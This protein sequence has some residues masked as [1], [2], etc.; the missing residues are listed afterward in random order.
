MGRT[1]NV[2]DLTD[3]LDD[4]RDRAA[5]MLESDGRRAGSTWPRRL[6]WVGLGVTIGAAAS[7]GRLLKMLPAQLAARVQD[8]T[9]QLTSAASGLTEQVTSLVGDTADDATSTVDETIELTDEVAG[10][11]GK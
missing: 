6:A 5:G 8:V 4:L 7:G 11:A 1:P 9:E 10:M 3:Q 2:D